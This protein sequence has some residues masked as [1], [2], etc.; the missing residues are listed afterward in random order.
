MQKIHFQ[1]CTHKKRLL[2]KAVF[3]IYEEKKKKTFISHMLTFWAL[4][5]IQKN[6][7]KTYPSKMQNISIK[8]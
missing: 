5:F 4:K 3:S 7:S 8:L 1:Q 6:K 2:H